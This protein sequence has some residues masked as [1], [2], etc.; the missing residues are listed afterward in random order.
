M[1]KM[2]HSNRILIA[3]ILF[4]FSSCASKYSILSTNYEIEKI[5][6]NNK[7]AEIEI[8]D[9]RLD[10]TEREIHLPALSF[11]W[12]KDKISPVLT[13]EQKK[14]IETQIQTYFSNIGKS[15]KVEC[16]INQAYK[17]FTAHAFYEREFVQVGIK[18]KLLD[19]NN[20]IIKYCTSTAF[21]EAKS[22]DATYDYI[23]KIYEKAIRT[24][25][26]KCFESL[27]E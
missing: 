5:N 23:N 16:E 18:I 19:E 7:L 15:V 14:M 22:F 12:Q 26:Y 13:I 3:L 4:I 20:N 2:R 24:S 1:Y 9:N 6:I 27:K 8:I 11:P 21:F 10:V 17:E 25:I